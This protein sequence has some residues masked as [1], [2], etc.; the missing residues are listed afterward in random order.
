MAISNWPIDERPREKLLRCGEHALSNTELLAILLRT[1]TNGYSA[2]DLGRQI[3]SKFKTFRNLSHTDLSTWKEIK[4]LGIAKITQIKAAVEIGRRFREDETVRYK[5]KIK[6]SQNV[7]EI[8]LP[9]MRDLKK[10]VFK[11]LFL[12]SKNRPIDCVEVAQGTVNQVR[13]MVRE[14]FKK[15][16]QHFATSI[17]CIHNHPSGD[18]NPSQEDENFTKELMRAGYALEIPVLDHIIIGNDSYYSFADSKNV[19]V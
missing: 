14:I 9:R 7:A 6:S 17:I 3:M 16:L 11:A 12:D 13:P 10:E 5:K 4:G 15:S 1:G 2:V 18:P 8:F 19:L